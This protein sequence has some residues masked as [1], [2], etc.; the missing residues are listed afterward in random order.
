MNKQKFLNETCDSPASKNQE[1]IIDDP[2]LQEGSEGTDVDTND[3]PN[4]NKWK[5]AQGNSACDSN[6]DERYLRQFMYLFF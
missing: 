2:V 6:Y 4:E 3:Q 1:T 5:I